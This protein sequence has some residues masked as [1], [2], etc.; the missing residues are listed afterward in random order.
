MKIGFAKICSRECQWLSEFPSEDF[1][2]K[3]EGITKAVIK[4]KAYELEF[5][6]MT[7][8]SASWEGEEL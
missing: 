1:Q 7:K 2:K 3:L 6:V 8:N 4:D 5:E